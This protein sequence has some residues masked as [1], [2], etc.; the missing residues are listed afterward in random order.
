[1]SLVSLTK[2]GK[3]R[4]CSIP[5]F[6]CEL[7]LDETYVCDANIPIGY[8]RNDIKG[9]NEFHSEY[10]QH[11][12]KFLVLPIFASKVRG[13]LPNGFELLKYREKGGTAISA[14]TNEFMDYFSYYGRRWND[15]TQDDLPGLIEAGW[16]MSTADEEQINLDDALSDKVWF[17]TGNMQYVTKLLKI[18]DRLIRLERIIDLHGL[19]HL[20]P[21]KAMYMDGSVEILPTIHDYIK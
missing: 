11:G 2:A 16:A 13:G 3:R 20:A 10:T 12:K 8:K 14:A 9:F 21:V 5:F 1:M 6:K 15:I 7:K 18:P 19:E 17:L 4:F